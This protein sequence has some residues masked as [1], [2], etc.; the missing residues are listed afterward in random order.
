MTLGMILLIGMQGLEKV[1]WVT[2]WFWGSAVSGWF[3]VVGKGRWFGLT[4]LRNWNCTMSPGLAWTLLG[5]N[6][7]VFFSTED[8]ETTCT[9]TLGDI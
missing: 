8:T 7:R 4:P 6:F 9:V 2:V 3:W 5:V 1:D